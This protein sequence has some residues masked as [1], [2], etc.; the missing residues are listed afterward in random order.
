MKVLVI[1]G[2]G[3]V[4]RLLTPH[5][6]G[7]H[8]VR[9][10]D[11]E[12]PADVIGDATDQAALESAMDG[13]DAFV[14][15]A[16]AAETA[17]ARAS[18]DVN[19][20]SVHLALLAAHRAGVPHAVHMS[21]MSVYDDTENRRLADESVPTDATDLYGLTKRLGEQVCEAAVREWAISVN[22][23]RLTWPTPDDI[24]PEWGRP[25]PPVRKRTDAGEPIDALAATDL[26]RAVL[27]A[28]DHRNGFQIFTI[29]GD[30]SQRWGIGNA[31]E[32]LGW[33]PTFGFRT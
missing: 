11:R 22:A 18:F 17:P 5:L 32:V 27:A 33:K 13:V 6:T 8:E 2:S 26:G 16:M 4:G 9:V 20:T 28:L 19:V 7:R 12:P 30:R 23:L 15:C 10:F 25:V 31:Q 1:G 29:S 14:H 21:S 3:Y 24:W